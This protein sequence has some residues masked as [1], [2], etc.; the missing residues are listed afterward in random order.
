MIVGAALILI[1][2]WDVSR[3]LLAKRSP[4]SN[5]QRSSGS[6][7]SSEG[8]LRLVGSIS[9][10]FLGIVSI[11]VTLHPSA[12]GWIA[13]VALFFFVVLSAGIHLRRIGA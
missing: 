5:S 3:F 11:A 10:A 13:I 9:G 12:P 8:E 6:G 1:G 2:L 4:A 7:D